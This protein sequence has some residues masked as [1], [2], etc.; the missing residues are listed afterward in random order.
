MLLAYFQKVL[1]MIL[2][3]TLLVITVLLILLLVV[4]TFNFN[5]GLNHPGNGWV[6]TCN[7]S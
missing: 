6:V 5:F 2:A 4:G 1:D 7:L 3:K